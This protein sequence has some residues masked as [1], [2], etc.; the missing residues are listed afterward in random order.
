MLKVIVVVLKGRACIVG[1]VDIDALHTSGVIRQQGLEGLEVVTLDEEV[2]LRGFRIA[3]NAPSNGGM[4][5]EEA[6]GNEG[7]CAEGVFFTCL[8]EDGHGM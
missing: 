1:R 4:G 3:D 8:G 2:I 7:G 6:K 5:L